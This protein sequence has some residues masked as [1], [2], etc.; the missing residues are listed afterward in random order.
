MQTLGPSSRKGPE[1][2]LYKRQ[3]TNQSKVRLMRGCRR[4]G[5]R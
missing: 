4:Y 3:E 5:I 1:P 2:V